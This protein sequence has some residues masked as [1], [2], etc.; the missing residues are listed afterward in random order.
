MIAQIRSNIYE[1][2]EPEKFVGGCSKK[3]RPQFVAADA[4]EKVGCHVD[5]TFEGGALSENR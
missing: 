4:K 2:N 3:E 5:M 1:L